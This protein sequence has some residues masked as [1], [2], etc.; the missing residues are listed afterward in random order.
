MVGLLALSLRFC[1]RTIE[2][3]E[4]NLASDAQDELKEMLA[5]CDWVDPLRGTCFDI[6]TTGVSSR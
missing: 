1:V 4:K 2:L 5:E 3:Y 6:A